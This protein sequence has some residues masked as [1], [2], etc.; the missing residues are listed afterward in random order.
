MR[1]KKN[2]AKNLKISQE[3][4]SRFTVQL[5]SNNSFSATPKVALWSSVPRSFSHLVT[6][7]RVAVMAFQEV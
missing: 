3:S 1:F 4:M 6:R 2:Q 5:W 7:K